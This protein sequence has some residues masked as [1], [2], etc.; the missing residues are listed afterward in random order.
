MDNACPLTVPSRAGRLRL[1]LSPTVSATASA[2]TTATHT[3]ALPVAARAG[4][5]RL[6]RA[7][8]GVTTAAVALLGASGAAAVQRLHGQQRINACGGDG[9]ATAPPDAEGGGAADAAEPM[10]FFSSPTQL[11]I[12]NGDA[13]GLYA[14]PSRATFC[15]GPAACWLPSPRREACSCAA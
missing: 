3:P 13:A 12:N 15:C 10:D 6:R 9:S 14:A 7:V 2:N 8:A 4:I 11:A 1:P 5:P